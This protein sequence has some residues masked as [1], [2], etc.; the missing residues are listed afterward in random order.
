MRPTLVLL[1][2]TLFLLAE[3]GV[4]GETN[5]KVNV[6]RTALEH[7]VPLKSVKSVEEGR[8]RLKKGLLRRLA[9]PLLLLLKLKAGVTVPALFGIVALVAFKGLWSGMTALAVAAALAVRGLIPPPRIVQLPPAHPH[10]ALVTDYY[11]DYRRADDISRHDD[12][13]YGYR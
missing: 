10:H 8:G 5:A 3:R 2:I 6:Q 12:Y 13:R 4:R 9:L 1:V 11:T 7:D